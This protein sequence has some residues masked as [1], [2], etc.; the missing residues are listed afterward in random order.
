[1]LFRVASEFNVVTQSIVDVLAKSGFKVDN[2]PNFTITPEMYAILESTYGEDKAKSKEHEKSRGDYEIRRTAIQNS[3]NDK[4][5]VDS[6]TDPIAVLAPLDEVLS[7]EPLDDKPS[8]VS[9]QK[10]KIEQD[11]KA[12]KEEEKQ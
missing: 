5:T 4:I 9:E 12:V 11:E 3:R 6:F 8:Q 1:K 10:S 2:K 7:L